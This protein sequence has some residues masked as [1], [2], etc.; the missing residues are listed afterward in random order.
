M[1]GQDGGMCRNSRLRREP[2]AVEAEKVLAL[3]Y[4]N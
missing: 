1:D 3:N 4:L 2:A